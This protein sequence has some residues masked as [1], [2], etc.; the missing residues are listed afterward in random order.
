MADVCERD[1]KQLAKCWRMCLQMERWTPLRYL[2]QLG[3]MEETSCFA[4][5]PGTGHLP[6]KTD[7]SFWKK[8]ELE[9]RGRT[10]SPQAK[11]TKEAHSKSGLARL[12]SK[13][14]MRFRS[15]L[16]SPPQPQ[17]QQPSALGPEFM[18]TPLMV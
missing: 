7:I 3:K 1:P 5:T 16:S 14:M 8:A 18:G 13:F 11:G 9:I 12:I 4:N 17:P 15:A 2:P 6:L 10:E